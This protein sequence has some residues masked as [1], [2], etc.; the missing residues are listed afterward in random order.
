MNEVDS[1]NDIHVRILSQHNKGIAPACEFFLFSWNAPLIPN[2][3]LF[4][5]HLS[6]ALR[7]QLILVRANV[8][9]H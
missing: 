2:Q 9:I 8:L 4:R 1:I 6:L 5:I 3:I 7:C